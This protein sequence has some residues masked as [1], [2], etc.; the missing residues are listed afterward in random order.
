M[1]LGIKI[2]QLRKTK[3]ITQKQLAEQLHMSKRNIEKYE[4][5]EITNI[6]INVL[7]DIADALD[8]TLLSLLVEDPSDIL[9]VIK[10]YYNLEDK[11][12]YNLEN[13]FSMIMKGFIDRY[14]K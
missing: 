4:S 10:E 2:K 11:P 5:N 13:D 3:G 9:S 12:Y 14:K 7:Q 1:D 6:N 8:V